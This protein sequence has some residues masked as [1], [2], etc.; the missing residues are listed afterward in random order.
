LYELKISKGRKFKSDYPSDANEGVILNE[1]AVKAI[2][3]EDPIGK[4]IHYTSPYGTENRI[5]IGVIKDF[6]MHSLRRKIS[7]YYLVIDKRNKMHTLSIKLNPHNIP[8]A[9]NFLKEKIKTFDSINSF[10]YS[11]IND[12][13]SSSYSAELKTHSIFTIFSM[14]TIFISCLGL[15]GLVSFTTEIRKKEFGIRKVLGASLYQIGGKLVKE[16]IILI[17]ISSLLAVPIA[18]YI[19]NKWL[20]DFAYKID[21]SP[22]MFIIASSIVYITALAAIIIQVYKAAAAD[23]VKSLRYE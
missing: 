4:A 18:Y 10:N 11:F 23:P 7:P 5:V 2:G 16:M 1:A 3:W 19:I 17:I 15:F 6:Y 9:I 12:F 20:M 22:G 21:I 8:A 14:F 13:L